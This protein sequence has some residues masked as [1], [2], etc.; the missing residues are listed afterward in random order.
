LSGL[1]DEVLV[2]AET[3]EIALA[4]GRLGL[5]DAISGTRGC[6]LG[7]YEGGE[8]ENGNCEGLHGNLW[9][10]WVNWTEAWG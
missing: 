5:G 1:G 6:A 9:W 4:A 10:I 2:V 3:I 7:I 8:G